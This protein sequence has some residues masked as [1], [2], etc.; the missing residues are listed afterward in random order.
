MLPKFDKMRSGRLAYDQYLD[1]CIWLGSMR[2][3]MAFYDPRGTGYVQLSFDQ[4]LAITP[5]YQ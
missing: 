2:K 1:L 5:Y 3:L 4:L